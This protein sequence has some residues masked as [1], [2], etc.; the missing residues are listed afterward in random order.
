MPDTA[1]ALKKAERIAGNMGYVLMAIGNV[2]VLFFILT[3]GLKNQV[4]FAD[5]V[6]CIALDIGAIYLTVKYF[7]KEN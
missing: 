2:G 7:G 6:W 5:M 3:L 1:L 4:V